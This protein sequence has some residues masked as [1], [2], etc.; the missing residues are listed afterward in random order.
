[1]RMDSSPSPYAQP[2]GRRWYV[3]IA[4][5]A[6][7]VTGLLVAA[8]TAEHW[9][10][11]R[12]AFKQTLAALLVPYQELFL[13]GLPGAE[14]AEYVVFLQPDATPEDVERFLAR[15]GMQSVPREG[16]F[17]GTVVITLGTAGREG[18]EVLRNQPFVKLAVRN[19][20]VFFCH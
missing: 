20:G 16:I 12:R 1:M 4:V 14:A 7:A 15:A 17:P 13:A 6:L 10:P 19:Q 5:T 18:L 2:L 9:L 8:L 11:E 3:A